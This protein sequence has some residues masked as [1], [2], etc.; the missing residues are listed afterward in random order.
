MRTVDL[1]I[2]LQR[3]YVRTVDLHINIPTVLTSPSR[4][5]VQIEFAMHVTRYTYIRS[6]SQIQASFVFFFAV[7]GNKKK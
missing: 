6:R 4:V 5:V 2:L 7:R 3:S 1:R